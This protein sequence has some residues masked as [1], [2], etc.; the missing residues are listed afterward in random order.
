MMEELHA[1]LDAL[2]AT[3]R[4]YGSVAVAFSGGVDSTFLLKVA[5]SALGDSCVAVTVRSC[6]FPK[7]EQEET[8]EFCRAE[9]IRHV[10][11]DV[12]VLSI[13]GFAENPPDRCYICKRELFRRMKSVA[14]DERLAVVC[15][16]SNMDDLGDY[17]PGLKAIAELGIESPL[18]KCG[19]TKQ[20]IRDLSR[21]M[22]LP[23]WHKPSCAC[24]ASRFAYGERITADGLARV[25]RAEQL[26]ADLGFTQSRA[27]VHGD[28]VRIEVPQE[29]LESVL[30]QRARIVGAL[31]ADGFAYVALD[32]QGYRTGSM[33]ETLEQ[34]KQ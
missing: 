4:N 28:L 20:D 3:L 6:N 17:R 19:L 33:N 25:D 10:I 15:E 16:G 11:A 9:G 27:R 13:P 30:A 8:S 5:H 7:L 26:L 12:D 34:E 23:T 21:E 18:R 1:K 31:K 22:H 14:A 32:L 24:L 2:Q 29:D